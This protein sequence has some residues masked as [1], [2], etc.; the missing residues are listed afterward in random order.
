MKK[1]VFIIMLL[2]GLTAQAQDFN[3]SLVVDNYKPVTKRTAYLELSKS[4]AIDMTF[5][6]FL[7][8]SIQITEGLILCDES[9][10]YFKN[11]PS[12]KAIKS[13]AKDMKKVSAK[14]RRFN[15]LNK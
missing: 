3:G 9:G 4:G 15:H 8:D 12:F 1:V 14:Q 6:A 5:K 10:Q 13:G 11:F 2:V 7:K